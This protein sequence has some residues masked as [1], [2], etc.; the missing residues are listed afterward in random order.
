MHDG[1]QV[2]ADV[3]R[4]QHDCES[5]F[6]KTQVQ[7]SNREE[8]GAAPRE[9]HKGVL[10]DLDLLPVLA[11]RIV[12]Q[13]PLRQCLLRARARSTVPL[14]LAGGVVDMTSS[15]TGAI[16]LLPA[17]L[18]VKRGGKP[19]SAMGFLRRAAKRGKSKQMFA[20]MVRETP[21]M[22]A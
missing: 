18:L 14:C 17:R 21:Q 3:V 4:P 6:P 2:D 11:V 20:F 8:P 13:D 15:W 9:P 10:L 5:T 19:I 12:F 1:A 7:K 22:F 16:V